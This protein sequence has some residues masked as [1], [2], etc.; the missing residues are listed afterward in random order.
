MDL[1]QLVDGVAVL[2]L[3]VR[4]R[5]LVGLFVEGLVEADDPLGELLGHGAGEAP[6]GVLLLHRLGQHLVGRHQHGLGAFVA[7]GGGLDRVQVPEHQGARCAEDQHHQGEGQN[8]LGQDGDVLEH[9]RGIL[10]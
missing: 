4:R 9:A 1:A 3:V 6:H 7:P 2:V 5:Q 8:Q 10:R